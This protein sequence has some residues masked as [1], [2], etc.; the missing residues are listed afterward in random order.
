MENE[1]PFRSLI[2]AFAGHFPCID[3]EAYVDISARLIGR[4]GFAGED[5]LDWPPVILE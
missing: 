4:V 1:Q 2:T 5:D 3:P